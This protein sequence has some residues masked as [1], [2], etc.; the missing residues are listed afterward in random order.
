MAIT[1]HIK[2]HLGPFSVS[3]QH[4]VPE[5][6]DTFELFYGSHLQKSTSHSDFHVQLRIQK[7]IRG[8]IKP[9]VNFTT[10]SDTPFYPFPANQA[11]PLYEWGLNWCIAM[12]AHQF[13]MFHSAVLEKNGLAI[14]LPAPPGSGKSTL[15]A[16]LNQSGWRLLSDEFGML[17]PET[18]EIH[19]LPRPIPLKN[20]SIEILRQWAPQAILG[21]IYPGTRKGD[22]CHVKPTDISFEQSHITATP[23]WVVFPHYDAEAKTQLHDFAKGRAFLKLSGN[24]FNYPLQGER[25]FNAVAK[26]IEQSDCYYLPFKNLDEA[27]KCIDKLAESK[28]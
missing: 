13:L 24:A 16:A 12:Q 20:A 22:L 25:G 19:P 5:F 3:V 1:Q 8:W 4:N 10:D 7:G 23:R 11:Y 15:C 17:R 26:V 18:G 2:Y 14:I 6:K 21:P 27:V 9:Q 28:H